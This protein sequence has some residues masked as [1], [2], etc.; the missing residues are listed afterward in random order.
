MKMGKNFG[1][2][3]ELELDFYC[4]LGV[5]IS[6]NCKIF[7]GVK[8]DGWTHRSENDLLGHSR[9]LAAWQD[10]SSVQEK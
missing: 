6:V 9:R 8:R 4:G 3:T 1:K 5:G 7:T 10:T 2:K